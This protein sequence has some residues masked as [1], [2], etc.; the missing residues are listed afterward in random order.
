MM[1]FFDLHGLFYNVTLLCVTF[2]AALASLWFVD[3]KICPAIK[4]RCS[5]STYHIVKIAA[6]S[7]PFIV[8]MSAGAYA[9]AGWQR[10]VTAD[11]SILIFGEKTIIA[12]VAISIAVGMLTLA[13]WWQVAME[14]MF[15]Y[16]SPKLK[17]TIITFMLF[18][19][20]MGSASLIWLT[21]MLGLP[22]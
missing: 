21:I 3:D 16:V 7:I 2:T 20:G 5:E 15:K 14:R 12:F 17:V 11:D 6:M 19:L 18:G 1:Q 22:S 10:I 9:R 13:S 4:P 8:S